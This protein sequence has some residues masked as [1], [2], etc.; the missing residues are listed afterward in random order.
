MEV[1]NVTIFGIHLTVRPVAFTL[2][3]G[4]NGW[5]IYW[6]GIIIAV[7]FLLAVVYGARNAKRFD[8]DFDKLLDVIIVTVPVAILCARAYYII[9]S[10][11]HVSSL[12]GFFGF[13]SGS[14]FSGIAIY[15]GVIGAAI[16]GTLMCKLKKIKMLDALDLA[17]L[18][19]LIGQG[20]GRWGNFTNQEAF[21][22]LTGST[23][24]GMASE[25]TEK[26]VGK[27]L[28]HPCFL[29]ESIW[30]IAGF[31]VLHFLSKKRR[32]SGEIA[33][34]YCVWYGFGRAIIE[35]LRTDSLKLGP[36]RV[37][38][39]LSILICAGATAALVLLGNRRKE[40]VRESEYVGVFSDELS[41][42]ADESGEQQINTDDGEENE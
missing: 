36:F 34:Y 20:V 4:K 30:C 25:N 16:C 18:G 19:F 9:F 24:W 22:S 32:F 17:A 15:G 42:D 14:G 6:Y 2:P 1:Y 26:L 12:S 29:Y 8:L 37:S 40:A 5:D 10:D 13:S 11:E 28:V 35:L 33:L 38:C 21:G 3:I 39:L 23:F 7:G 27:G 41:I 31:F